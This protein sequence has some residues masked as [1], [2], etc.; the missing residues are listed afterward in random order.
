M[1]RRHHGL[2]REMPARAVVVPP[3]LIFGEEPA[4]HVLKWEDRSMHRQRGTIAGRDAGMARIQQVS[5]EKPEWGHGAF[6]KV[7]LDAL[8][9]PAADINH[10]RLINGNGFAG[11]IYSHVR[12]LTENAQTP[13]MEVAQP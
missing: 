12:S 4:Y 6:T 13:G 9:D 3:R 8:S 7:P 2:T 5:G 1:A 10:D 11:Y